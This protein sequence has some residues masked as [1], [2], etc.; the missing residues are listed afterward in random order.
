ME[1][2]SKM[3]LRIKTGFNPSLNVVFTVTL[4]S[5]KNFTIT[6]NFTSSGTKW[7]STNRQE[8]T[9]REILTFPL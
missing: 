3:P 5:D 7:S 4:R 9:T 1:S 8:F 2:F 6:R